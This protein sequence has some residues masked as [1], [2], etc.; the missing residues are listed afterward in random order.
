MVEPFSFEHS[1]RFTE[2]EYVNLLVLMVTRPPLRL[3]HRLLILALTVA[4]L[5]WSYTLLLG[6]LLLLFEA[7]IL[8]VPHTLAGTAAHKY[9]ESKFIST[10][11]TYG[12]S[13]SRLWVRGPELAAEAGWKYLGAWRI[14]DGWLI[15]PCESIPTV[16]LPLQALREAGLYEQV[17]ALA[18]A[19]G[20]A[21]DRPR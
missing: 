6:I 2:R 9:R 11:M 21:F 10:R 16:F 20:T 8:W 1:H 4:C 15:L 18:R 13:E 14:R 5:L 7:L 19:H 17:F 12:V 3:A